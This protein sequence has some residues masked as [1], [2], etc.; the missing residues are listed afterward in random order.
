MQRKI[1]LEGELGE[2][3]GTNFTVHAENMQE[4]FRCIDANHDGF[5]KYLTECQE[6]GTDFAI[7]RGKEYVGEEELLLS[8]ADEDITFTTLEPIDFTITSSSD[9]SCDP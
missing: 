7:K 5:K 1:Y 6:S 2:K 4:I 9:T 3:F 8:V